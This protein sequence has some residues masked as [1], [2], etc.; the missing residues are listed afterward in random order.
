MQLDAQSPEWYRARY[1]QM[2][3]RARQADRQPRPAHRPVPMDETAVLARENVAGGWYW[4]TYLP[5]GQA[6]RLVNTAG[7]HGV[8]VMLWNANDVSE[9]YNPA[10][11][12]K[13]QWTTRIT[14]GHVLLSD[15][16]RV[17]ASVLN[18]SCGHCDTLVGG[19]SPDSN[20]RNFGDARLRNTRD[21][22]R[23][24]V[25]KHGMDVRDIPVCISFFSHV[26]VDGDGRF[27]WVEGGVRAGDHVDLRAEMN[28]LVGVSNCPHPFSSHTTYNPGPI[29]VV[30]WQAPPPG[31]GDPRALAGEEMRRAFDA[32]DALFA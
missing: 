21:N 23:L 27:S 19:S 11:T 7:N 24:I 30:R 18:D 32:T 28:L 12:I 13:Q 20:A 1:E 10:D 2:R 14:A 6:L 29:E 15:M 9:R 5:R 31:A 8:A 17:L 3:E 4:S 22:M 25:G 26:Q 16:E